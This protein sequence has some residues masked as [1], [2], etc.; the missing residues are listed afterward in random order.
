[1]TS[2]VEN[3]Q[4]REDNFDLKLNYSTNQEIHGEGNQSSYKIHVSEEGR[5]CYILEGVT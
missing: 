3:S 2:E 5:N 4:S 1:L